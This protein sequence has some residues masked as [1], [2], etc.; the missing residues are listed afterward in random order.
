VAVCGNSRCK[1]RYTKEEKGNTFDNWCSNTC[2]DA[3]FQDKLTKKYETQNK[4]PKD[5]VKW[6]VRT[7]LKSHS[8]LKTHKPLTNKAVLKSKTFLNSNST[9]KSNSVLKG[10]AIGSKVY[11]EEKKVRDVKRK[12]K[13][14]DSQLGAY[15]P[16]MT[17]KEAEDKAV[18]IC[19]LFIRTRDAD[20]PCPCCGKPLGPDFHAGHFIAAGSCSYLKYD[21]RNIHGQRIDC[22]MFKYGDSGD[23]EKNLRIRI[24]DL[25]VEQLNEIANR[26]PITRRSLQDYM[27]II[28]YYTQALHALRV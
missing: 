20:K 13:A 16:V 26:N 27:V 9:L 22:N 14:A 10:S 17:I 21:E 24:G 5:N 15:I 18:A 6:P 11:N 4:K 28:D 3:I 2:K 7:P 25:E 23:Y 1:A 12:T 19:H 8:T